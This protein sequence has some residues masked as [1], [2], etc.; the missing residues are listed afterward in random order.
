MM[1]LR[2]GQ[3]AGS[4]GIFVIILAVVLIFYILLLPDDEFTSITDNRT[5]I[6]N[7]DE[8]SEIDEVLL[9]ERI[10]FL[11]YIAEDKVNYHMNSFTIKSL[12]EAQVIKNRQ[13]VNTRNAVFQTS[14]DQVEFTADPTRTEDLILNFHVERSRGILDIQLNGNNLFRGEISEGNAPN[15]YI[16]SSDLQ[17]E[18]ELVFQVSS[19]GIAFWRVNEYELSN[20]RV[21]G[22]VTDLSQSESTQ[23]INI[24][25]RD[26]DNLDSARLRYI[27]IC[28]ED[29]KGFEVYVNNNNVFRGSPDCHV[30]NRIT[31]S[32]DDLNARDN[33][34]SFS[35][36]EGSVLIDQ[37]ELRGSLVEVENPIYYF[38]LDDDLFEDGELVDR[39]VELKVDFVSEGRKSL[40][41]FVNGRNI[42]ITTTQPEYSRDI[43]DR[44]Q[45]GSNSIELQ[46]RE[47]ITLNQLEVRLR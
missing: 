18:N 38:D 19:P 24:R 6:T 5:T 42:G 44:V 14:L 47:D 31:I 4:S 29:V 22:D 37:P 23:R 30:P 25:E 28:E 41:I 27:P 11:E 33:E 1:N 16:D 17:Y 9:R 10:G 45:A 3:A 7:G 36:E 21:I 39:E 8:D 43:S 34:F 12:T 2:K 32:P 20:I 40:D 46:A 15:I 13:S 35:V 26:Y